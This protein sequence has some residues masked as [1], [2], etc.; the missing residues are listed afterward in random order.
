MSGRRAGEALPPA[1]IPVS[2][3]PVKVH[4]GSA[5]WTRAVAILGG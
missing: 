1:G 4:R 5:G 3:C 2:C